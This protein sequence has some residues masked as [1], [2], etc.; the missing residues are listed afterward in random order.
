MTVYAKVNGER[1]LIGGALFNFP[2]Y[3][4]TPAGISYRGGKYAITSISPGQQSG[5]D[6]TFIDKLGRVINDEEFM[7]PVA[8]VPTAITQTDTD[9]FIAQTSRIHRFRNGVQQAQFNVQSSVQGLAFDGTNLVTMQS[10]GDIRLYSPAGVAVGGVLALPS[11]I[12]NARC[13]DV[14]DDMYWVG[15]ASDGVVYAVSKVGVID[16][17]RNFN[18]NVAGVTGSITGI[19]ADESYFRITTSSD[20]VYAFSHDGEYVGAV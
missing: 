11:A 5:R 16:G 9:I 20:W 17:S 15:D 19:A 13:I 3:A 4:R 10:D 1:K 8:V 14:F 18:Y 7:V 12:A 6:V 2:T